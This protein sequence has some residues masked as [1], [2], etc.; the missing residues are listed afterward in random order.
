[1]VNN[2]EKPATERVVEYVREK[3]TGINWT[4]IILPVGAIFIGYELLKS[5]GLISPTTP[6]STQI[7]PACPRGPK[8]TRFLFQDCDPGYVNQT[9]GSFPFDACVCTATTSAPATS[10]PMHQ[11]NYDQFPINDRNQLSLDKWSPL[12]K[13]DKLKLG[14]VSK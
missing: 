6:P 10:A 2:E 3:S 8:Y 14:I 13:A 7:T 11:S 9:L 1:M 4:S 12:T 5:Q